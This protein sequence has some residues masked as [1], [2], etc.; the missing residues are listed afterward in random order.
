MH[1]H[2]LDGSFEV[3]ELFELGTYALVGNG[4]NDKFLNNKVAIWENDIAKELSF[5]SPILNIRMN[6]DVI[7]IASNSSVYIY[8][9]KDL[10]FIDQMPTYGNPTGLLNINKSVGSSRVVFPG[11]TIGFISA[12]SC[13]KNNRERH[14]AVTTIS[15]H[16]SQLTHLTLNNEGTIVVSADKLGRYIFICDSYTGTK[17]FRIRKE[18]EVGIICSTAISIGDL[19][20]AIT[21][22]VGATFIYTMDSKADFVSSGVDREEN[23]VDALAF[24]FFDNLFCGL[25]GAT[26]PSDEDDSETSFARLYPSSHS[27]QSLQLHG[28]GRSETIFSSESEQRLL[29]LFYQTSLLIRYDFQDGGDIFAA[30]QPPLSDGEAIFTNIVVPTAQEHQEKRQEKG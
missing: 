23:C 4:R 17:M 29:Q 19:Y 25:V 27:G 9:L 18:G 5:P 2:Y 12:I 7:V 16:N 6:A 14:A 30:D 11:E 22:S 13:K 8:R 20:L 15:A 3:V 21:Y 24:R 28:G 10:V 26:L 1:R